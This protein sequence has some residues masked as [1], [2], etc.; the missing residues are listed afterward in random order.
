[1]GSGGSVCDTTSSLW[2]HA[3]AAIGQNAAAVSFGWGRR[4]PTQSGK[5]DA[6]NI[7]RGQGKHNKVRLRLVL[8]NYNSID[9]AACATAASGVASLAGASVTGPPGSAT[10]EK[11]SDD[12]DDEQAT[13]RKSTSPSPEPPGPSPCCMA[14]RRCG[15]EVLRWP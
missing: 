3:C 10:D 7:G 1:M 6:D 2:W 15:T 13:T 14:A 9:D 12:D 8:G 5:P 11:Y 4:A